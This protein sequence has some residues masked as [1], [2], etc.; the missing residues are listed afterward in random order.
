MRAVQQTVCVTQCISRVRLAIGKYLFA[1]TVL[2]VPRV[3]RVTRDELD[4]WR[5]SD[6][7]CVKP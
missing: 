2:P 3:E 1:T 5:I 6:L 7:V 4:L